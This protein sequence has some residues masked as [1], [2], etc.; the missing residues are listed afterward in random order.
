MRDY[1]DR[2]KEKQLNFTLLATPAEGFQEDL[3]EWIKRNMVLLRALLT[4]IITPTA[5]MFRCI[6]LSRHGK[7][8]IEAP[9]HALTNAGNITYVELDEIR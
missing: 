9:Y 6:I 3:F 1:L 4:G 8:Q 2:I 5:S 7:I